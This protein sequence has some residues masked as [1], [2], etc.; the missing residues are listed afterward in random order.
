MTTFIS[1]RIHQW[2][3]PQSSNNF[4]QPVCIKRL[5]GAEPFA[6]HRVQR[7][8]R[9]PSA[10]NLYLVMSLKFWFNVSVLN[11]KRKLLHILH[12]FYLSL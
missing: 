12:T 7:G 3:Y 1:G 2:V 11:D 9:Q 10:A 8:L 5:S 4:V 6:E